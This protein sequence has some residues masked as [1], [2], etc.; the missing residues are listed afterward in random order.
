MGNMLGILVSLHG[1]LHVWVGGAW[2]VEVKGAMEIEFP[3]LS[4]RFSL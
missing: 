4:W 3:L 1:S 2:V